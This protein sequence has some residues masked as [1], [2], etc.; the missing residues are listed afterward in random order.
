MPTSVG[1]NTFGEENLVFAFDT[2]D[3]VNSYK[4]E[5]TTNNIPSQRY[6]IELSR[7]VTDVSASWSESE[8]AW[9]VTLPSGSQTFYRGIRLEN[10]INEYTT[11]EPTGSDVTFSYNIQALSD[12]LWSFID[13]NNAAATGSQSYGNDNR[14][15]TAGGT[16]FA[17]EK[18]KTYR[19]KGSYITQANDPLVTGSLYVCY[20]TMCLAPA[21]AT[22]TSFLN[23]GPISEPKTVKIWNIQHELKD[24]ATQF[25][26]GTRTNTDSLVDLTGNSTI[27]LTNVSFDSN[28]Q[29]E[30]DGTNDYILTGLDTPQN[31]LTVSI[32]FKQYTT[33]GRAH[34]L[35][36][37]R[38]D[39]LLGVNFSTNNRKILWY[40]YDSA[41]YGFGN[42]GISGTE[43]SLNVWNNVVYWNDG[44]EYRVYLNGELKAS[45]VDSGWAQVPDL[46]IG[47][48][49]SYNNDFFD[50][51]V[52]AVRIYN[53]AL[54]ASEIKSNFNAIKGRFNI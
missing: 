46:S 9:Y 1:P 18:G 28:A 19:A 31:P 17:L 24:H 34:L 43:Y 21:N 15:F 52:D 27:D 41:V 13:H 30:F 8:Q 23:D 47:A 25:T 53:R 50:G 37:Y 20:S 3:T 14:S 5:P 22:N 45:I 49:H 54:T 10:N 39:L 29:M 11:Y 4:G 6:S 7:A 44:S 26:T 35:G 40:M 38:S 16:S 12:G 48:N 2:G 42:A 33:Q 36:N 32:W 51:K